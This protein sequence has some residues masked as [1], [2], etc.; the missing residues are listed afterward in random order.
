MAITLLGLA[1]VST[2]IFA[3]PSDYFIQ[4]G[5]VV[6]TRQQLLVLQGVFFV[7]VML[8]TSAGSLLFW[9][10]GM[11]ALLVSLHAGLHNVSIET[12]FAEQP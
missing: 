8:F 10:V 1:V 5:S 12:D 6:F 7:L 9:L 3:Q 4:M 2:L 11:M